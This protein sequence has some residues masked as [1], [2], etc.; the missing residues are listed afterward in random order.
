MTS[1]DALPPLKVSA[2]AFIRYNEVQIKATER[3]SCQKVSKPIGSFR[4]GQ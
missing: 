2:G 3:I 1:T 4:L